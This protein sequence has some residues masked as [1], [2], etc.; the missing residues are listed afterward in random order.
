MLE[1]YIPLIIFLIASFH[2]WAFRTIPD[3][4]SGLLA[5]MACILHLQRGDFLHA[6]GIGSLVFTGSLC[7]W[8]QGWMGGGDVKLMGAASFFLP[9]D[10]ALP[11]I[12][13]LSLL[14]G[15]LAAFY[16]ALSFIIES[17]RCCSSHASLAVRILRVERWRISHR[18]PLPY[19]MA[20][21]GSAI[22]L[23]I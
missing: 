23:F 15:A 1:F 12:S 18:R 5:I 10:Q 22:L 4:L 11:F 8:L 19:A 17:P 7:L 21:S 9:P 2:D 6:A 14:G 13:L 20:I 16:F 3:W